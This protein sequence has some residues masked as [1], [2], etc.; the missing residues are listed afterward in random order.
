M[1]DVS[2]QIC[3]LVAEADEQGHPPMTWTMDNDGAR[4]RWTCPRC[5]VEHVRS[6]EAKLEPEWW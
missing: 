1:A 3:G 4:V 6:M 5:S 2:C